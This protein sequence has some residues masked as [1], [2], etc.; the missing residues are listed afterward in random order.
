MNVY[1]YLTQVKGKRV[2]EVTAHLWRDKMYL[3]PYSK[4]EVIKNYFEKN[5]SSNPLI[6]D[7]TLREGEQTPG[8]VLTS[9]ERIKIAELL[10]EINV[11]CIEA[12]FPASSKHEKKEV[13][14]LVKCNFKP[15]IYGFARA[16]KNDVDAVIECECDGVVLSS[17]PSE[18]HMKHKLRMTKE[19]YLQRAAELVA[20][21]KEHGLEV[22]YSAEDSTRCE[23]S[24]LK[25]VFK[26]MTEEGCDVLR[27][28]DT[29]GC[30][31]PSGMQYL[32]GEIRRSFD[33]PIEVHCHNDHGLALANTLVAYEAGA[34]RF[35]TSVLGIGERAGIAATEE[36]IVALHNFYGVEKYKLEKL[37]ELCRLVSQLSKIEI[38]PVKPIVGA[39]VFTHASGIH[40]DGVLKNPMV[41]EC[42]PPE[43][44]GRKRSFLISRV[45]GKAIVAAKLKE[46]G[47]EAS[48]EEIR[49]I[50]NIVKEVSMN[51]RSALSDEE[52]WK[53][54]KNIFLK[55]LDVNIGCIPL[56]WCGIL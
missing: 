29:V 17:P 25:R 14:N 26:E 9:D 48:P 20:Y 45:S 52:F 39:N 34:T 27:V 22:I 13:K 47:K 56:N 38:W 6:H 15:K 18:I 19:E 55:R 44:V 23:L 8:V 21:S 51:R 31:T 12:G 30:I 24:W 42:F 1:E 53:S 11:D 46:Y 16:V 32:I 10:A 43:M 37:N 7:T 3:S 4:P 33:N 5:F 54:L 36:F 28:V 49:E 50:T 41:Y 2:W 35:S 40:Q